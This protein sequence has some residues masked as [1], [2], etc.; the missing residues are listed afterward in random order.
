MELRV[1]CIARSQKK[2]IKNQILL[3]Q[4]DAIKMLTEYL[5]EGDFQFKNANMQKITLL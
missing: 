3:L 5:I 2:N 1:L 4:I